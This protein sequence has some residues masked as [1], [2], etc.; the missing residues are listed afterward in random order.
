MSELTQT[1]LFKG[2]IIESTVNETNKQKLPQF[3]CT[4]KATA[5]Y[6]AANDVW[7]DWSEYEDQTITGYLL[8]AYFDENNVPKKFSHYDDLILATDWDGVT[9]SGLAS[10]DWSNKIVAFQVI[11]EEYEGQKRLKVSKIGAEDSQLGGLRKLSETELKK[12]DQTFAFAPTKKTAKP[13]TAPKK[14]TSSKAETPLENDT[15]TAPLPGKKPSTAGKKKPPSAKVATCTVDEAYEACWDANETLKDKKVPEE[16]L[17]DYWKSHVAALA[18]DPENITPEEA[19]KIRDA[20][21][22]DIN[23]PF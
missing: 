4:L 22:G 8:L 11:E 18:K 16:I 5:C 23:I 3:V 6:D 20:V 15:S 1:G 12:L 10:G 9:Y 13:A 17:D 19:A 14:K 2:V 21:L 7:E